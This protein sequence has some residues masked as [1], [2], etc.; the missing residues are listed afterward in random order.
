MTAVP[1][2]DWD[3][4]AVR[5]PG[6]H[7]MQS[8]AWA[9]IKE[10]QGW[11]A[12]YL[13]LGEAPLPCALV[14]WRRLPG[15]FRFGYSPR[16]P[17]V[18]AAGVHS[19][20]GVPGAGPMLADPTGLEA[21]LRGLAAHA[22]GTGALVLKVD[23]ELDPAAAAG[24]LAAA[25]FRRGPDIQPV[26]ATLMLDLA[27]EIDTLLAGCEKDTRWSIKQGAKRG[28]TIR[29][30]TSDADLDRFY[31][32]YALTGRRARFIT[33]TAEYYR[34]TWRT[35]IDAGLADLWLA[36]AGGA[37]VAAAMTWRC[38]E[39]E[40][41]MYGASNDA[42]RKVYAAYA[43]QWHCIMEARARG[44][45]TYDFG[46]VP[47]DLQDPSDTMHGPYVFK[48]GFG[49]T[50]RRFVGA[51]DSVPRPLLYTAF[52][53]GEPLYSRALRLAGR[54]GGGRTE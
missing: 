52:R 25:G 20:G 30:G 50:V 11:A 10:Q 45:R 24:P 49:G 36:E 53:V 26:R 48:K 23:P 9:Q 16:G 31:A 21:A 32:L 38:G 54:R 44:A 51:H 40:L 33:R 41:Y 15:G 35:L 46:G 5:S 17:V 28:V 39:R 29:R 13:R 19:A 4:A 34:L 37:P 43:L 14:L 27:P 12:E 1:P 3:T 2:Q 7:V 42:G 47:V 8:T 22:R 18:A 6:G